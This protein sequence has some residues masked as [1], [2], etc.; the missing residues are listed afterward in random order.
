M[1]GAGLGATGKGSKRAIKQRSRKPSGIQMA[2]AL[3]EDSDLE[4]DENDG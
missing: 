3:N 2:S 4:L 1:V